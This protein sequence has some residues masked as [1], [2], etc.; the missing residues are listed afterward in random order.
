MADE[1]E[2]DGKKYKLVPVP[3]KEGIL[4]TFET[5]STQTGAP[6]STIPDPDK[7]PELPSEVPVKQSDPVVNNGVQMMIK[8]AKRIGTARVERAV[9]NAQQKRDYEAKIGRTVGDKKFFPGSGIEDTTAD[10]QGEE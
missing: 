4:D 7:I 6:I 8:T 1:V 3:E 2:I 5:P 10:D 9:S